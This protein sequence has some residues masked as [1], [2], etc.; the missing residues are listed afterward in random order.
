MPTVTLDLNA[1][2]R[3]A[4]DW[5]IAQRPDRALDPVAIAY[6]RSRFCLPT[7]LV[8]SIQREEAKG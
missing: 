2:T 5:L 3:Q 4:N 6:F 8:E 7:W 1:L